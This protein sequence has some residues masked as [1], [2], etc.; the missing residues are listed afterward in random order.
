M[1]QV[2]HPGGH[3]DV[4]DAFTRLGVGEASDTPHLVV[5]SQELHEGE[6]DLA[7]GSG[8]EDLLVGQHGYIL[9]HSRAQAPG[10]LS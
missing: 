9:A 6:G 5:R 7:G 10:G 3:T 4:L 1:G 8:D 2:E